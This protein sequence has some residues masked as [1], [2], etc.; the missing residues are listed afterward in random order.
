MY[1]PLL[2]ID[3]HIFL[4]LDNI[5][6]INFNKNIQQPHSFFSGLYK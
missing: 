4:Y 6:T 3:F 5:S 1:L 2:N